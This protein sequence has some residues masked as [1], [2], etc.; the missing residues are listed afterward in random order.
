MPFTVQNSIIYKSTFIYLDDLMIF[1]PGIIILFR[2]PIMKLFLIIFD[3]LMFLI[4][5]IT[6]LFFYKSDGKAAKFLTGYNMNSDDER[7]R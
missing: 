5:V 6:G 2:R 3:I 7:T 1:N 4:L